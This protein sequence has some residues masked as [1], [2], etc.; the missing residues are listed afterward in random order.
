MIYKILDTLKDLLIPV[1]LVVA[2]AV[3]LYYFFSLFL[4]AFKK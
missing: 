2:S 4:I 1:T 3:N